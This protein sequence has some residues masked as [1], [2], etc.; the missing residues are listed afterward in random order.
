MKVDALDVVTRGAEPGS[1]RCDICLKLAPV[2][3]ECHVR[4]MSDNTHNTHGYWYD[5][6]PDCIE[7]LRKAPALS[8][9]KE[10]ADKEF[11]RV[12][13]HIRSRGA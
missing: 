3:R 5:C 11:D 9:A 10:K 13:K 4:Y 7:A 2:L 8:A 1:R 12:K 6:C